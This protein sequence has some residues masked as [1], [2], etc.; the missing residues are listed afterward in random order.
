MKKTMFPMTQ[1]EFISWIPILSCVGFLIGF[2]VHCLIQKPMDKA[3][4]VLLKELD[5]YFKRQ[6]KSKE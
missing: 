6:S 3:V 4:D 5:E 1:A 2:W